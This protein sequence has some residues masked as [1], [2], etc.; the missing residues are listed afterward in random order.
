[1]FFFLLDLSDNPVF[2]FS[3][4]KS[5]HY[6]LLSI[7]RHRLLT[8]GVRRNAGRASG[9]TLGHRSSVK[10][11]KSHPIYMKNDSC[12]GGTG[13]SQLFMEPEVHVPS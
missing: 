9:G 13:I 10:Q 11:T 5:Y 12:S 8:R 3:L 7:C 2:F 6:D 1:M 4:Y